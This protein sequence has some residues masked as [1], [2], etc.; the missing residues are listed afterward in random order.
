MAN[1][2]KGAKKYGRNKRAKN[3]AMSNFVRGKVDFA[4]YQKQVPSAQK[5][6]LPKSEKDGKK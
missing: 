3:S 1:E 5:S 6:V 2:G 4:T